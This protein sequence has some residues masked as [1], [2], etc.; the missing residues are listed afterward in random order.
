MSDMSRF[1][2]RAE[3][4]TLSIDVI[5]GPT[6]ATEHSITEIP[7]TIN[8]HRNFQMYRG[9]RKLSLLSDLMRILPAKNVARLGPKH[10]RAMIAAAHMMKTEIIK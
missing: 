1:S 10:R 9:S 3:Y 2:F 8:K 4:A 5:P 7:K 6:N